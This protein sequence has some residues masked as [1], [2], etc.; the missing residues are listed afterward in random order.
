MTGRAL[1]Q[2]EQTTPSK[3]S[4]TTANERLR[5]WRPHSAGQWKQRI[6]RPLTFWELGGQ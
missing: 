1:T 5:S 2:Q 4:A 3:P 6:L